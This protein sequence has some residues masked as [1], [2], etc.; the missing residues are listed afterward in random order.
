MGLVLLLCSFLYMVRYF[1][2]SWLSLT[3][4]CIILNRII[5]RNLKPRKKIISLRENLCLF[6]AKPCGCNLF[7]IT[8]IQNQELGFPRPVRQCKPRL[9]DLWGLV[10]FWFSHP[11]DKAFETPASLKGELSIRFSSHLGVCSWLWFYFSSASWD[12]LNESFRFFKNEKCTPSQKV[13]Y[14]CLPLQILI[15]SPVLA[16]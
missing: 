4:C 5:Y 12:C 7:G 10:N 15:F 1:L 2:C 14:M 11:E 3:L 6:F 8:L 13:L 9:Q 16:C